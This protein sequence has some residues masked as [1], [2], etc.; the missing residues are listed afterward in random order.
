LQGYLHAFAW[1]N[2]KCNH[3]YTF[4]LE[5]LPKPASVQEAIKSYFGGE[6]ESLTLAPISDWRGFVRALL[7]RWLFQFGDSSM[8]HLEDLR[9]SFSLFDDDFRE[10]LLDEMVNR[11]SISLNPSSVW[12]VE[13]D[14]RG[15]YECHYEDLAF[16]EP[17]RVVYLHLG[18]SD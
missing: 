13:V 16:E 1:F 9:N 3:G 7:S 14:T 17:D 6:L 4:T 18:L 10:M 11:L 5:I 15:F 8:D 12:K 2:N